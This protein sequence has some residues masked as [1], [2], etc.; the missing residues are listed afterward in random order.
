MWISSYRHRE[1]TSWDLKL[2]LKPLPP[3]DGLLDL[4]SVLHPSSFLPSASFCSTVN[5]LSP[6]YRVRILLP[7]FSGLTP[8]HRSCIL[9]APSVAADGRP[10]GK[11]K[12][13]RPRKRRR[14]IKSDPRKK[15]GG[16]GRRGRH[17]PRVFLKI[18]PSEDP[19]LLRRPIWPIA[20]FDRISAIHRNR[21]YD[22]A[23]IL[24]YFGGLDH[25]R[26]PDLTLASPVTCRVNFRKIDSTQLGVIS[27][28]LIFFFPSQP[29]WISHRIFRSAWFCMILRGFMMHL[30]MS[31]SII[32][33]L[34]RHIA[35]KYISV[36][37]LLNLKELLV[38][39]VQLK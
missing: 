24:R 14:Y 23:S 31:D 36:Y 39:N 10:R 32:T 37:L 8:P 16:V 34:L 5:H 20:P 35:K 28:P 25:F 9:A 38:T 3:D 22:R 2:G 26:Y 30:I 29:G 15:W 19:V 11:K 17:E 7:L 33:V 13:L 4:L 12:I 27:A 21:L 1:A 6:V 18:F